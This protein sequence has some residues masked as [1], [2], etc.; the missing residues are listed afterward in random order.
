MKSRV[1]KGIA[2]AAALAAWSGIGF[3][4][5]MSR[6]SPVLV[7]L[8]TSEGCS[9][10]PPADALLEK[11]DR[12]NNQDDPVVI[13]L[14]EHVDY[15]DHDGWRDPY[16]S[17][18]FSLRQDGYAQRFHLNEVYTP[19]MVVDGA[20]EFV[21]SDSRTAA[22]RIAAAARAEKMPVK[23]TAL[24]AGRVRV[25][26]GPTGNGTFDVMLALAANEA[27]SNVLGGENGGRRLHHVAVVRGIT[28]IGELHAGQTF[29]KDVPLK[30]T[31]AAGQTLRVIAWVQERG[32]G[33]IAGSA[34]LKIA[35]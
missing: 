4:G 21:G 34:M 6:H 26:A 14:S 20:A 11:L 18:A 27:N 28:T 35:Q 2:V 9:S 16:S 7:E 33:R 13:V 17:A 29:A 30:P 8:F 22:S 1:K 24:G 10:C 23:I 31:S 3:S 25:E 5:E 12:A 32:Q 19:E 15:W